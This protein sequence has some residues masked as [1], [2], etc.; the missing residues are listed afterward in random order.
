MTAATI[1]TTHYE[2]KEIRI[3]R[4]EYADPFACS[5]AVLAYVEPGEELYDVLSVNLSG[6]MTTGENRFFVKED[7]IARGLIGHLEAEG[8]ISPTG[9]YTRY[10]SFDSIAHEYELHDH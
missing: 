3:E 2:G 6:Y 1:T 4:S 5:C 7:T 10:G 8:I 9:V